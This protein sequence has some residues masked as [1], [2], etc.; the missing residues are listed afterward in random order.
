[1]PVR[2]SIKVF[3]AI[4]NNISGISWQSVLMVEETRA[5]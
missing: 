5:V 2:V 4:F 1:M 3:N